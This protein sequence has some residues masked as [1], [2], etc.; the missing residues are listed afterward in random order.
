MASSMLPPSKRQRRIYNSQSSHQASRSDVGNGDSS[1]YLS[2]YTPFGILRLDSSLPNS[3]ELSVSSSPSASKSLPQ[4]RAS[5]VDDIGNQNLA[6]KV[7]YPSA[8]KFINTTDTDVEF[9]SQTPMYNPFGVFQLDFLANHS[10]F[11]GTSTPVSFCRSREVLARDFQNQSGAADTFPPVLTDRTTRQAIK[12]FQARIAGVKSDKIHVCASCGLFI[13]LKSV[14]SVSQSDSLFQNC[15]DCGILAQRHLDCCAC[16]EDAYFFCVT[17]FNC[18][19]KLKPPKFGAANSVNTTFCQSFP[20]ELKDLTLAEEAFIAKAH[21]VVSILKLKPSKTSASVSYQRIRGH[22]VVLP[23]NPG[24]LLDILPSSNL[25]LHDILRIVW[26]G[27]RPHTTTDIRLFAKVKRA[28][29][30]SAL[31]WLQQ[32]NTL[33]GHIVINVNLLSQWKDEFVLMGIA[34]NVAQCSP[35]HSEKQGYCA[36]LEADNLEDDF[37]AAVDQAELDDSVISDCVYTDANQT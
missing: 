34:E 7:P 2:N 21:P 10:S 14:K 24:P 22:A 32:N 20:E 35:D 9:V 15:I 17:C 27:D 1:S 13:P 8:T 19:S 36:N 6:A 11:S 26:A 3:N 5:L 12:R 18:I 16:H 31:R 30:F 4:D 29:V 25:V 33:Y 37:H 23:Q 28:K